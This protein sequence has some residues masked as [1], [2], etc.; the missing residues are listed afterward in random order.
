MELRPVSRV[1]LCGLQCPFTI[2]ELGKA[3]KSIRSGELLEVLSDRESIIE[4]IGAWCKAT[5]AEVVA[6]RIKGNTV[7]FLRKP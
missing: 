5:G 1:D 4:E 7:V 6:S 2:L 3:L